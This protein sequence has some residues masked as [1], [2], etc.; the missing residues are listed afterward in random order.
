MIELRELAPPE[1][2]EILPTP[3]GAAILSTEL[4]YKLPAGKVAE[5]G[6]DERRT[7]ELIGLF[8][9]ANNRW[10]DAIAVYSAMYDHFLKFQLET[11]KR[12]HKGMPL[13]WIADCYLAL[14]NIPL[15]KRFMMLTLIEDAI[16]SEGDLDPVATGSYFRL[17]WRHGLPDMEVKRYCEGAYKVWQKNK[18][19]ALFPEF[20]LQE[21]D[22]KWIIEV[23]SPNDAGLYKANTIYI[24]YLLGQLGEG[25]GKILE[26]LADYVLSC[27]PGCRTAMRKRSY[28]TDYDIVCTLEGPEVDFRADFG[29]YFICECKDW[30]KPADFSAFAKFARVLD[31]IKA[32]FGI[33]FSREG[34]S[35]EG[36]TENAERE[37][38]KV[39]QDRGMVIVVID[40]HDLQFLADSGNF[41]SLLRGK[42]EKVRLDLRH[43]I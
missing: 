14:V 9:R 16:T 20:V 26:R 7:W 36:S 23:P 40:K 25:S 1:W 29:R 18:S 21:L 5:S 4:P 42:Y 11:N 22:K 37:Q 17:A 39:F 10:H 24:S 43:E 35:G 6:S 34:I 2:L 33:I 27:V 30:K 38:V 19:D 15:S 28:S 13:V 8:Y 12:V 3:H 32:N 31:S 41:I